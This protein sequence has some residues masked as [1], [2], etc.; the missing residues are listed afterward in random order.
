MP[1]SLANGF[2]RTAGLRHR[3]RCSQ[4]ASG[5]SRFRY[6]DLHQHLSV[7]DSDWVAYQLTVFRIDSDAAVD[8]VKLPEVSRA[9]EHSAL[10]HALIK[11][12][13][14]MRTL[15][16]KSVYVAVDVDEQ[17]GDTIDLAGDKLTLPD[18]IKLDHFPPIAH[19]VSLR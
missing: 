12:R 11:R 17:N 3:C 4:L 18:L 16:E 2:G 6:R 7:F 9:S 10:Q 19:L 8:D 15:V 14:C 1:D 13:A 5:G